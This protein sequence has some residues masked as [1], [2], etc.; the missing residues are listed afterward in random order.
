MRHEVEREHRERREAIERMELQMMVGKP[1]IAISNE[2][3][4]PVIGFG[5]RVEFITQAKNPVLVVSDY[6]TFDEMIPMSRIR[7][8]TEQLMEATFTIDRNTLIA[9]LYHNYDGVEVHKQ[10][11]GPQYTLDEARKLLKARGFYDRLNAYQRGTSLI[12]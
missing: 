2:V 5:E 4:S 3:Q 9:L 7:H 6:M 8:Y 11:S 1:V 12:Q 10:P